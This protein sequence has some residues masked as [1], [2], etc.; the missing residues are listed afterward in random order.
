MGKKLRVGIFSFTGDEGCVI[1]F[2]EILN[3][4]IRDWADK[5]DF[6]H[7]RVLRNKNDMA[8]IDV[9][10]VEGAIASDKDRRKLLE[11]RENSK[12][13]VAIGTCAIS[14]APSNHRNFFD[15]ATREE[16]RPILQQFQHLEKVQPLNAF[17]R[18]DAVVPGC[19]IIEPTFVKVMENYLKEFGVT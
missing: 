12:K 13:V 1:T 17:V 9:S 19:P 2:V 7:A 8:D 10:F 15:E 3:Y 14:G 5:V 6:V 11:I 4:K 16:I 18:V